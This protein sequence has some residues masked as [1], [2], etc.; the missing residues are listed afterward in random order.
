MEWISVIEAL[1]NK[2]LQE[3]RSGKRGHSD[4]IIKNSFE[5]GESAKSLLTADHVFQPVTLTPKGS[6]SF[7]FGPVD[8]SLS[9]TKV[10]SNQNYLK[11]KKFDQYFSSM[12]SKMIDSRLCMGNYSL[13]TIGYHNC[14]LCLLL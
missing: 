6:G 10:R 14:S 11:A 3:E 1:R 13:L 9:D 8:S 12:E 7:N 5:G 2:L 4:A